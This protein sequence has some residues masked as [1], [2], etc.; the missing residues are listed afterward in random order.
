VEIAREN[1][2]MVLAQK[3]MGGDFTED[4]ALRIAKLILRENA[5]R[6]FKLTP[7]EE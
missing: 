2:A 3:V 7:K 6:V 4:E 1:V 5:Q